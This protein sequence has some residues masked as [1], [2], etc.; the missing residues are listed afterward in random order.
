[1]NGKS[2]DY[3]RLNP[4]PRKSSFP[5]VKKVSLIWRTVQSLCNLLLHGCPC[6]NLITGE[7]CYL[8]V[9]GKR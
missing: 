3:N 6:I 5:P 9:G 1:M 2:S 7:D 4:F 8:R